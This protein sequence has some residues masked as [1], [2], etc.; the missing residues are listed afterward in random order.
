M[1]QAT[2]KGKKVTLYAPRKIA[3][4]TPS[5]KK[6]SVFVPGKKKGTAKVVHFGDSSMS[7]FT[8]HHN[9][10]RRKNFHARHNCKDKKDKTKARYWACKNLW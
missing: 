1:A 8:Q 4:V 7:D 2:W 9:E 10:K 5:G 6:K 3:G